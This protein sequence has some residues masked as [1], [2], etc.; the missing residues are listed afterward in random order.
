MGRSWERRARRQQR[1]R[2]CQEAGGAGGNASLTA[3]V[4]A[5]MP[6]ILPL[7]LPFCGGSRGGRVNKFYAIEKPCCNCLQKTGVK[8]PKT[9]TSGACFLFTTSGG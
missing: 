1:C 3:D 2:R 4:F 8:S 9:F 7:G 6:V 5:D